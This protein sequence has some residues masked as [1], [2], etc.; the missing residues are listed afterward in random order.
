MN[1]SD[2]KEPSFTTHEGLTAP[3]EIKPSKRIHRSSGKKHPIMNY[4]LNFI[5]LTV[6]GFCL[7]GTNFILYASSGAGNIFSSFPMLRPDIIISIVII[8]LVITLI[9]FLLSGFTLMLCILTSGI[10]YMFSTAMFTQFSDFSTNSV[11]SGHSSTY[12]S[13]AIAIISFVILFFTNKKI[14]FL[15]ACTAA[16]FFVVITT[17]QNTTINKFRTEQ[18]A[19]NKAPENGHSKF[20]NIMIPGLPSYSYITTLSDENVNR[21][22]RDQLR[23]IM[24][25]FYAQYGFKLFPNA[26]VP[27]SYS[28]INAADTLNMSV[29]NDKYANIK[30]SLKE[31]THWQ[32]K[33]P[34]VFTASLANSKLISSLKS[35]GYN[36]NA[37]QSQ[38][39]KL[40][41]TNNPNDISRCVT[42][43]ATPVNF[44]HPS[45]SPMDKAG[46]LLSQWLE[47]TGWFNYSA[48]IIYN[49]LSK[50]IDID[51]TPVISTSYKGLYVIDS[52][53]TLDVALNDIIN[54]KGNQA[55]FIMLDIPSDTFVYDE[56]CKLKDI[57]EWRVKYNQPWVPK[58]KLTE[59]RSAYLRQ[60]MCLYGK[61]S[62]FMQNLQ[63]NNFLADSTVIIQ[64]ISGMND[65][66][67]LDD[68]TLYTSFLNSKITSVAI[69]SPNNRKFTINKSI[70][71][72]PDIINQIITE[73]KCV[74]FNGD[75]SSKT[76]KKT[77]RDI[78]EAIAY[79]NDI[80]QQSYQKYIEWLKSWNQAN[81]QSISSDN[82][83]NTSSPNTD[84]D[85]E[86]IHKE[87]QMLPLE[88]KS[89][90][91]SKVMSGQV[92]VEPEAQVKSLSEMSREPVEESNDKNQ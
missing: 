21:I 27:D 74:D 78:L 55:Y 56:M 23:S 72:T 70:C 25:G 41:D 65:M 85:D 63:T 67:G 1:V 90:G 16:T 32:F 22:Y 8:A 77:I 68:I 35:K 36:I 18:L 37:Y 75:T 4:W 66:I 43:I 62:Q 76:T 19:A 84:S 39:L 71:A 10:V 82:E 2:R 87:P 57:G 69:K 86:I 48:K 73:Q 28:V 89:I 53:Q 49:R 12:I 11:I 47:S 34:N 3:Y 38:G 24:L 81:Y 7:L 31:D 20:I 14:R 45:Y 54:D 52:L 9:Y 33:T 79:N 92:N 26:Y 40:C 61:L 83:I 80:A 17:S 13:L 15:L 91:T 60:T 50:F 64:G 46:I 42:R 30:S 6:I 51:Q 5:F 58:T 44:E 29:P 88:E 59:K